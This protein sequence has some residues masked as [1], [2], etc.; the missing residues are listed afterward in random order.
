M[1]NPNSKIKIVNR[2]TGTVGYYIPELN[3]KRHMEPGADR[4]VTWEEL[5]LLSQERG[6]MYLIKNCLIVCNKEAVGELF[7][8]NVEPEYYYDKKAIL[9]LLSTGSLAQLEDC[10]NFAPNS[11]IDMVKDLAVD[12][13]LNDVKKRELILKKTDFNVSAAIQH[14]H[15]AQEEVEETET[16]VRKAEPISVD[17]EAS[18]RR[19]API[20][21]SSAFDEEVKEE[22]P[23][24]KYS[25]KAD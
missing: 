3:I 19:A 5:R 25:V 23:V 10:L 8:T 24:S 20:V 22:E 7:G 17:E 15:E 18:S 2:D 16:V 13:E 1:L 21:D 6:G 11:V 12:I 14:K 9:T 4:Y